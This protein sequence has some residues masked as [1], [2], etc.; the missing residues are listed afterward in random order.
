LSSLFP[1]LKERKLVQWAV[2][3]AAAAWV[4]YE[5]LLAV[6]DVFAWPTSL[7]RGLTVLLGV[8][9]L[10]VLVIGWNHGEKG[11][12]RVTAA[13]AIVLIGLG[14]GGAALTWWATLGGDPPA[15]ASL[16]Y[17]PQ[18]NTVAVLPCANIGADEGNAAF[19]D[20]IHNDI[21]TQLSKISGVTPISRTSV[22]EYRGTPTN[23]RRIAEDL[24]VATV[25]EC[26]VQRDG[27]SVRI[28]ARL[29]DARTDSR[30]WA[31]DYDRELTSGNLFAIQAQVSENVASALAVQLRPDEKRRIEEP[32]TDNLDAYEL[33]ARSQEYIDENPEELVAV[34]MLEQAI[35]LD[36]EFAA[37]HAR[38]STAHALLHWE[39]SVWGWTIPGA[40]T[41]E[42]HCEQSR[43]AVERARELDP[44]SGE[45]A[46]AESWYHYLC[47]LDYGRALL[48]LERAQELT[49]NAVEILEPKGNILRRMGRFDEAIDA[50]MQAVELS[51]RYA[52]LRNHLIGTFTLTRRFD[53]AHDQ[54]ERAVALR[55]DNALYYTN[56]A[57]ASVRAANVPRA[58]DI[59]ERARERGALSRATRNAEAVLDVF[60]GKYGEAIERMTDP[61]TAPET[62][63]NRLRRAQAFLLN[64]APETARV[65]FDSAR[66][67]AE[68]HVLDDP[69]D[70]SSRMELARAYAG[71]DRREEAVREAEAAVESVP[72]SRDALAGLDLLEDLAAVYAATGEED[73][74]IDVLDQL[75]SMQS[76][77]IPDFLRMDPTWNPLR[78]NSRFQELLDR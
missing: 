49:P 26:S 5:V 44:E 54:F 61:E 31:E 22:M 48:A 3:Y 72:L 18:P 73:R 16:D 78:E 32:L 43:G 47:N 23:L 53:E 68:E 56:G 70:A 52:D 64:G 63:S 40:S 65:L 77:M 29:V 55:P 75:L 38:L 9:F 34:R 69:D 67:V 39:L 25:M 74:A 2:A 30:L 71:L 57:W 15:A 7:L 8:G 20:G 76:R 27:G 58:R 12:Q 17:D 41:P 36:P 50:H 62:S 37:A 42:E 59:I 6:G 19:V 66:A 13:E 24:N 60:E 10:A 51:P 45:A 21:L 1:R 28:S 33:Y 14:I 4:L 46:T 11:H 35:E